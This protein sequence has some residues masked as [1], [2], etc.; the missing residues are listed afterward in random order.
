M[1]GALLGTEVSNRPSGFSF[2]T[3]LLDGAVF[4]SV[5]PQGYDGYWL[6]TAAGIGHPNPDNAGLSLNL[7][8]SQSGLSYQQARLTQAGMTDFRSYAGCVFDYKL[9]A[10]AF[11]LGLDWPKEQ[12]PMEVVG[13]LR[14]NI[15]GSHAYTE[16]E[17]RT[18]VFQGRP[19]SATEWRVLVLSGSPVGG[20]D[21]D[22][23]QLTDIELNVSARRSLC[24]GPARARRVH[25]GGL[26]GG[27]DET[28]SGYH[29]GRS[30]ARRRHPP[31]LR[32]PGAARRPARRAGVE[33]PN[34]RS[35]PN[36]A[37]GAVGLEGLLQRRGEVGLGAPAGHSRRP[38]DADARTDPHAGAEPHGG[39]NPCSDQHAGAEPG[40][41]GAGAAAPFVGGRQR[42][43][44]CRPG[45]KPGVHRRPHHRR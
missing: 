13:S 3:S 24:G 27:A 25:A 19:V 16:P 9:V 15:N 44:L 17:F 37:P 35:A 42:L 6:I 45:R 1:K 29:T 7:K 22:L 12:K 23:Q 8:T 39:K 11:M 43:G 33:A 40:R 34:A 36:L 18:S 14:A 28:P 31:R 20:A 21:M 2:T 32:E 10:P 30:R 26:L 4:A 38:A 5:V 41:D